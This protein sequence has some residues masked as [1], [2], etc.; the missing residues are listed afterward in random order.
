MDR[1][2]FLRG[3]GILG[4]S[5][6]MMPLLYACKTKNT[7]SSNDS[8]GNCVIIPQ[9]TAGPYDI[10]LSATPGFF[11]QDVTEGKTGIP[12]SLIL[13][14]INVNNDCSPITN[15]RVDIW[16]CDKDGIY[17]GFPNQPGGLDTTGQTFCRGI[18]LT[19]NEGVANFKT[20]YPG[21]Y[22]GRITHIHFQVYLNNG[23]S[24]TSQ[25][26]FPDEINE[27]VYKT[28]LYIA[29]GQNTT[30]ANNSSDS[31]FR[32][33]SADLQRELCTITEDTRVGGYIAK[34]NVGIAA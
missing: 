18:Q 32:N 7:L 34:L 21:W 29:K 2:N 17:S 9:E 19:N 13:T 11:R 3:A 6:V 15:A 10:D 24:A 25:L 5:S 31:V 12:L 4:L 27:A 8:S 26:A 14:V 16:H 28:P 33:S 20:I 23:L 1:K 22:P 30:V